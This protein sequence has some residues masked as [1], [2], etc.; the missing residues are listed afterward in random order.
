MAL[1]SFNVTNIFFDETYSSFCR[2]YAKEES[3]STLIF[4]KRM[5][6]VSI[7]FCCILALQL[8]FIM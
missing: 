2:T 3:F 7:F 4:L 1:I 8:Q 5:M 6:N